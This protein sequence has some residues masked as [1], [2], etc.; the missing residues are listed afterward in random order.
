[1]QT[2]KVFILPF[3]PAM[4]YGADEIAPGVWY[5]NS[6]LYLSPDA[7]P[8]HVKHYCFVLDPLRSN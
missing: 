1:M 2:L 7:C 3:A 4:V 5:S 6:L 8:V